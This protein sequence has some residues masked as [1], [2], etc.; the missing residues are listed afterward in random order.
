MLE[1]E[2]LRTIFC[3]GIKSVF[4][5]NFIHARVFYAELILHDLGFLALSSALSLLGGQ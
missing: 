1:L 2:L 4:E 5:E 3:A